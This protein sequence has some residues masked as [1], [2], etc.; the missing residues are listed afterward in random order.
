[1]ISAQL[2][3]LMIIGLTLVFLVYMILG[4]Y[5]SVPDPDVLAEVSSSESASQDI[6]TLVANLNQISIDQSLFSSPLFVSL[7]DTSA[8]IS[9]E[10]QGRP[11]PF[12]PI[13]VDIGNQVTTINAP[14]GKTGSN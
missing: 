9:P 7:Q 1:M 11:N 12:S 2:Q 5:N 6:L 8:V 3:K 14:T 4:L 13:G 10:V